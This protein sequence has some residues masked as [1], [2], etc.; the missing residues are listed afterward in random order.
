MRS[1][2]P[3]VVM[4][5]LLMLS[6]VTIA[7]ATS[8]DSVDPAT[9]KAGDVVTATGSD[10][11]AAQVS[12]LYLTSGSTDLKVEIT[13]QTDKSIKFK[14]PA[15]IKPGRWAL[16]INVK[17]GDRATLLELPVKITVE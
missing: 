4:A 14:V 6:L 7:R 10:V 5:S 3:A 13:E 12:E 2:A 16:M 1:A 17:S 15:A 8:L 9:A 11:G